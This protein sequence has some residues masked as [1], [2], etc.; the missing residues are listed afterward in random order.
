MAPKSLLSK[1]W[2]VPPPSHADLIAGSV[3]PAEAAVAILPAFLRQPGLIT[4]GGGVHRHGATPNSWMGYFM[5][6]PKLTWMI[7][8]ADPILGNLHMES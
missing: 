4:S 3:R 1:H 6:N 5:E 7:T 8:R 2:R